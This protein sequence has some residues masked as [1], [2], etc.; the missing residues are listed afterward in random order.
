MQEINNI[1][2]FILGLITII[3]GIS[4]FTIQNV[5]LIVGILFKSSALISTIIIIVINWS[6]FIDKIKKSKSSK[7]E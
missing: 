5:D 4:G 7:N 1:K 3:T 2:T 6:S